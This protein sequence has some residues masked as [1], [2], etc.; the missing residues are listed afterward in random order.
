MTD[1]KA[2]ITAQWTVN[3]NAECPH[4]TKYVDL[5]SYA[6]FWEMHDSHLEIAEHETDSANALDIV[7]PECG[8]DFTVCCEY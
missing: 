2:T 4:C 7:C 1:N 6:D 8:G 3:L 5:L